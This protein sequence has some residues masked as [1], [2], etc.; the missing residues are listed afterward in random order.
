MWRQ[1]P[2]AVRRPKHGTSGQVGSTW[3]SEDYST[4]WSA[5]QLPATDYRF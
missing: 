3:T 4:R 1:P 5:F 2:S